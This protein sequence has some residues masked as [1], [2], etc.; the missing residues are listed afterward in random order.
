[1]KAWQTDKRFFEGAWMHRY[2]GTYYLSYSTGD[3]HYLVYATGTSPLGP[4][5]YRGRILNPVVGWTTQG[6]IVEFRGKWYLFYHDASLSHQ[7]N[8]RCIKYRQLHYDARG[9]IQ[10]LSP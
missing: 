8:L 3:T 5:R 9:D 7:D 10:T 1:M 2:R 4:F 6:S